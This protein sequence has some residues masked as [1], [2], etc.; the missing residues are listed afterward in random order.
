MGQV[1]S[2]FGEIKIDVAE[3]EMNTYTIEAQH[4]FSTLEEALKATENLRAVVKRIKNK[5]GNK[6]SV[7][8]YISV[9]DSKNSEGNYGYSNSKK[10]GGKR[11]FK[12]EVKT[13]TLPHWHIVLKG[14][15]SSALCS[16]IV[17]Y[18]KIIYPGYIFRKLHLKEVEDRDKF[19][20]YVRKQSIYVRRF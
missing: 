17:N 18:L 15:G 14:E 1:K 3:L 16:Y 12:G 19:L 5:K 8:V 11:C 10:Y 7:E 6:S 2:Y 4:K 13:L 9:I 20:K